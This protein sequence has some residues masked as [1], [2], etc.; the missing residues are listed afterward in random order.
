MRYNEN[1]PIPSASFAM[2]LRIH[3]LIIL[4]GL[5]LIGGFLPLQKAHA[6]SVTV[7]NSITTNDNSNNGTTYTNVF[8]SSSTGYVFFRDS[9]NFCVYEKTTDGGTTWGSPVTISTNNGCIRVAVW[10]DQ[11]TPGNSTG[12]KIRIASIETTHDDI[13]YNELN[14]SGDTLTT[15]TD[16][17]TSTFANVFTPALTLVSMTEGTDGTLY[18]GVLSTSTSEILKCTTSCTATSSVSTHWTLAGAT[19]TWT[20][21]MDDWLTLNPLPNG[22]ILAV[23][24]ALTSSTLYSKVWHES[25]STW[26][27][28]WTTVDNNCVPNTTYDGHYGTAVNHNNNTIY[29]ASACAIAT[30]NNAANPEIKTWI[31]STSTWTRETDVETS[32]TLGIT[33]TKIGIDINTGNIYV[34]YSG[35]TTKNQSATGNVYYKESTSTTMQTWGTRQGPIN[36]TTTNIYGARIDG[37]SPY[38]L[39]ATWA[40]GTGHT[41][42]GA[43][44]VVFS[45][46]TFTQSD[47]EVYQNLNTADV[48]LPF[49]SENASSLIPLAGVPFRTRML[50]QVAGAGIDVSAQNFRLQYATSSGTC[51]PDFSDG[52]SYTDVTTSTTSTVSFYQNG[53]VTN[54]TALTA[55]GNDPTDGTNV[56]DNETYVSQNPFTDSVG[57]ILGGQDGK[58]DFSLVNNNATSGATFCFRM[59]NSDES[60]LNNYSIL[61]AVQVDSPPSI[62]NLTL[63]GGNNITLTEGTTTDVLATATVS[64]PNGFGDIYSISGAAYRTSSGS[65]C[66]AN[67]NDCYIGTGANCSINLCGG[68]SCVA[69][70]DYKFFYYA[71]PT[72]SGTPWA[73]DTWTTWMQA[74]DTVLTGASS[75][76]SGVEL[77]SLLAFTTT[78]TINYGSFNQGQSMSSLTATSVIWS[79]G[80]VAMDVNVYGTNMIN[81][82]FSIPVGQQR[83]A[84]AS[85]TYASGSTLLANPGSTVLLGLPKPTTSTR[86]GTPSSTFFWGIAIPSGQMATTYTGGNSFIGVTKALPWPGSP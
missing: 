2:K 69:T 5:A 24:F 8:I 3:L 62:S 85:L 23:R 56:I 30:L 16:I 20:P 79:S 54:G 12:T 11:W 55:D 6:S 1:I 10:Y 77:L 76:S 35:R 22:N 7:D 21:F 9:T 45:P 43:S 38:R 32:S 31:Y 47:Y 63:N 26:D 65:A 59:V 72:D 84:T 15:S 29:M 82:A 41:L 86:S 53:G 4:C 61:P 17:T 67:N 42:E 36:N 51:A 64:D 14:T 27:A 50:M 66:T 13:W 80:N 68:T 37:M 34:V 48:G 44:I 18:A 19:S 46:S 39:Y 25:S 81:G 83:Y 78:S 52:L 57:K 70:C 33:G 40:D 71:Q 73:S 49:D 58:W 74:S 28:S 75:T 60:L